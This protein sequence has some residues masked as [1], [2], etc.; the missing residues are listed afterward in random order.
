MKS[1]ERLGQLLVSGVIAVCALA[2]AG[3]AEL[4]SK[5]DAMQSEPRPKD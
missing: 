5:E 4:V 3:L 1:R 2:A